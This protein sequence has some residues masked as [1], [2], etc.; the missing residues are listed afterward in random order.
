MNDG[1]GNR[2]KFWK[3]IIYKEYHNNRRRRTKTGKKSH[4]L[5]AIKEKKMHE[6]CCNY[7]PVGKLPSLKKKLR[8]Q[9]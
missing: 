3:M 8:I 6:L 5:L 7:C 2:I 4:E 1:Q 9:T